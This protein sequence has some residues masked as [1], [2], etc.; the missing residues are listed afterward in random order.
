MVNR[1][2]ALRT[3]NLTASHG[4]DPL[5]VNRTTSRMIGSV[6]GGR[7]LPEGE[8]RRKRTSRGALHG[9]EGLAV[10]VEGQKEGENLCDFL[11]KYGG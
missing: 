7:R 5:D 6:V 3:Q 4:S 8:V 10:G 11:R 9:V 2:G 1:F